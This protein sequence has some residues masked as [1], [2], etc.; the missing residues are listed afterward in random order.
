MRNFK[1]YLSACSSLLR[2]P[3]YLLSFLFK[4]KINGI[5]LINEVSTWV[6]DEISSTIKERLKDKFK[7]KIDF[8]PFF[9]SYKIIHYGSIHSI[10][11]KRN[12]FLGRGNK[13]IINIYHI[14]NKN[15]EFKT[16][17]AFL[18]NN[19]SKISLIIVPNKGLYNWFI[20][21]KFP[22]K[23]ICQIPIAYDEFF[24]KKLQE[25]KNF[26]RKKYNLPKKKLIIGSFQKD[27]ND[28]GDGMNPKLIKGPDIFIEVIKK[29]SEHYNLCCLLTGPSRGYMISKLRK[30]NIDYV[31]YQA[32]KVELCDLYTSLDIYL[33]TSRIEGGP[34]GLIEAMATGIPV[35][36]TE[37]GMSKDIIKHCHNGMINRVEDTLGLVSSI[38]NIVNDPILKEKII[39]NALNDVSKYSW[40]SIITMYNEVYKKNGFN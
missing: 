31:H 3:S 15:Y 24:F 10:S 40:R 30:H 18:L 29:L 23:K 22:S 21:N 13:I 39:K 6:I 16:K 11:K 1:I 37:V 14:D 17:I 8:L 25:N 32:N 20:K 27:G 9:Y 7:I 34:K 2:I 38:K 28:W 36:S 19:I 12:M 5:I 35:V 26:F 4:R 33:I